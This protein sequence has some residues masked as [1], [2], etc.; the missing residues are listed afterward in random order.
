MKSGRRRALQIAG[1]TVLAGAGALAWRVID[2][3]V[4][5]AGT[6]VAYDPWTSWDAR[7]PEGPLHLV[8]AAILAANPH[9]SQ[10]WMFKVTDDS[11]DLY[12]DTRRN[13]GTI[14]PYLREMYMGIGCA[15]EN[16]VIAAGQDG[17]APTVTFLPDRQNPAH[18]ASIRLVRASPSS[19]DLY[20]AIAKRHTNRAPYDVSRQVTPEVLARLS[21]LGAD[22][23]ELRVLWFSLAEERRRIGELIVAASEAIVADPQQSGDSARWFRTNWQQ[24]QSLRD[25]ITLDAQS[26]PPLI[27]AAAKILPPFDQSSADKAWLQA[28]RRQVVAT[29]AFGLIAVPDANNNAMRIHGGRL[30]QR[31]HLAATNTGLA[32][33]PLNQMCERMDRE[34]QLGIQPHFG[35]ALK[36][37]TGDSGVQ[38]LMPFRIG[39]PTVQARPSPRRELREVL[40]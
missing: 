11:I 14:D 28:T 15:L 37:L 32:A 13:I 4:F 6:G 33:Q 26:L 27:N 1:V 3:G 9:N 17:Y 38:A 2:Q 8:H 36:A 40:V 7:P 29:A 25:G 12:A 24:V 31:L 16:L 5:S 10:P 34:Q 39:Y 21:A 22:M 23:P 19:S 30:W 20:D 18:A 35:D